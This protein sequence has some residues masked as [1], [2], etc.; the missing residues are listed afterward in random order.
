MIRERPAAWKP[1]AFIFKLSKID[2]KK[3]RLCN[4]NPKKKVYNK[5]SK[6]DNIPRI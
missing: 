2:K 3:L 4:D 5:Y 6:Q 1:Q